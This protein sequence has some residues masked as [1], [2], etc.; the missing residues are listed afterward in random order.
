V[1]YQIAILF[2]R[3]IYTCFFAYALWRMWKSLQG[4]G[5]KGQSNRKSYYIHLIAM[6]G[7]FIA[8]SA[9][10]VAFIEAAW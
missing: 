3:F 1:Y 6:I 2:M 5:V 7:Y 8:R 10:A 9:E 4:Q